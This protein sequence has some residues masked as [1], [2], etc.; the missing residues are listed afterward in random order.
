M[1]IPGSRRTGRGI[2]ASRR[3]GASPP[4]IVVTPLAI[5]SSICLRAN[6]VNVGIDPSGG[7]NGAF[8]GDR[9][10]ARADDHGIK[11]AG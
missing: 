9:F 11:F 8:A 4:N 1:N 5:A 2:R 3:A 10:R 7:Q 6:K